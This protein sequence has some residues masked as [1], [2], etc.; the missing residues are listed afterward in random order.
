LAKRLLLAG[1]DVRDAAAATAAAMERGRVGERYLLGAANWSMRTFIER[2]GAIAGVSVPRWPIPDRP[3]RWAARRLHPG[4]EALGLGDDLNPEDNQLS[5]C[6]F[7]FR[8]DKAREEHLNV[9]EWDGPVLVTGAGGFIGRRVVARLLQED[10]E[11]RALLLNE[12][13]APGD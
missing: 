6:F 12:E 9:L 7:Y 5:Q 4:L 13:P 1:E 8:S 10:V 11:V 2:I 3:T